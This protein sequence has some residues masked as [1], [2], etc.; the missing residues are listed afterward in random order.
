MSQLSIQ[1]A[2]PT[3]PLQPAARKPQAPAAPAAAAAAPAAVG[4]RLSTS[5]TPATGAMASLSLVDASVPLSKLRGQLSQT[6]MVARLES[7]APGLS[8][9]AHQALDRLKPFLSQSDSMLETLSLLCEDPNLDPA[10]QAYLGQIM[11]QLS[12]VLSAGSGNDAAALQRALS[13][14]LKVEGQ[15]L[16]LHQGMA[17]LGHVMQLDQ[18]LQRR[19]GRELLIRAVNNAF[20]EGLAMLR[21]GTVTP[22]RLDDAVYAR[23][24]SGLDQ[25]NKQL[26]VGLASGNVRGAM[27][28][29]K[30][31][32]EQNI[33][34]PGFADMLRQALAGSGLPEDQLA[35]LG[36][37]K[38]I[39]RMPIEVL[40]RIESSLRAQLAALP[41]GNDALRAALSSTLD[42]D[43]PEIMKLRT[44][45]QQ[46]RVTMQTQVGELTQDLKLFCRKSGLELP[47]K[48]VARLEKNPLEARADLKAWIDARRAGA[49]AD[50]NHTLD[51]LEQFALQLFAG[52]DILARVEGGEQISDAQI[53]SFERLQTFLVA[54]R[55]L[56][57]A[58]EKS[59]GEG[60]RQL[61]Q[62][63]IEF[64]A[65]FADLQGLSQREMQEKLF[66]WLN[67]HVGGNVIQALAAQLDALRSGFA[68][69]NQRIDDA[70]KNDID[71]GD[72]DKRNARQKQDAEDPNALNDA[73]QRLIALAKRESEYYRFVAETRGDEGLREA[74]KRDRELVLE[75]LARSLAALTAAF[76]GMEGKPI[77]QLDLSAPEAATAPELAA[78]PLPSASG[79]EKRLKEAQIQAKL[80]K[81]VEAI[82]RELVRSL[83]DIRQQA[84]ALAAA[85]RL[86]SQLQ[87]QIFE[88]HNSRLKAEDRHRLESLKAVAEHLSHLLEE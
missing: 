50:R 8:Y 79:I 46:F 19:D 80:E 33:R 3:Q 87:A 43:L 26:L 63:I 21:S 52:A 86:R 57:Q 70:R 35:R 37:S 15:S 9:D 71:L 1:G 68:S 20:G 49:D 22:A 6:G 53:D 38:V 67:K 18:A 83:R 56:L 58:F 54:K 72:E 78:L 28:T 29:L 17:H 45:F 61:K 25:E 62:A 51:G 48:L 27:A 4:D 39:G 16:P 60:S 24:Q 65:R 73:N 76:A 77:P 36:D 7:L 69:H 47:A 82:K 31:R 81:E 14:P 75:P 10:A 88:L 64:G 2:G 11:T 5:K 34:V 41:P 40:A 44:G 13:V 55:A 85:E 74:L 12:A 42:Q 59:S 32:F 23:L 30:Q 84:Q 66:G